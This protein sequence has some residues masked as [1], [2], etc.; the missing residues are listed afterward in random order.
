M[1][2]PTYYNPKPLIQILAEQTY[3]DA[4]TA[5]GATMPPASKPLLKLMDDEPTPGDVISQ[6]GIDAADTTD[7]AATLEEYVTKLARAHSIRELKRASE[8]IYARTAG[9]L[10]RDD[11][12]HMKTFGPAADKA[13]KNLTAALKELDPTDPLNKEQAFNTDTTVAWKK[14]TT[15]LQQ[16]SALASIRNIDTSQLGKNARILPIVELPE[17]IV[18]PYNRTASGAR[19]I[20]GD[21]LNKQIVKDTHTVR[22][23]LSA[24]GRDI[25]SAII[26]I[27]R[28]EYGNVK[29][30]FGTSSELHERT[31]RATDS[32][33]FVE[34]RHAFTNGVVASF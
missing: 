34:S 13:I 30:K 33:T 1:N 22:R 26:G 10:D 23:L 14:A 16:L 25:D 9:R 5:V 15:A 28:G 29:L 8:S 27:A 32:R 7:H 31:Q 19:I 11:A 18:E 20:D 21:S 3:A 6:F 12:E 17:T 2:E 24:A 4:Y